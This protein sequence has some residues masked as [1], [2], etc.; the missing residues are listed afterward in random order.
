MKKFGVMIAAFC[1]ALLIVGCNSLPPASEGMGSAARNAPEG[2]LIGQAAGSSAQA[3]E[4]DAKYQLAR[5]MSFMVKDLVDDSVAANAI[6]YNAAEAFRQGVNTALGRNSLSAAVKEGSGEGAGKVFW[7]VYYMEKAE[8]IKVI[9]QA[10]TASKSLH[11]AAAD[12]TIEGRI[13]R[14]YAT[15]AA[16]EWKKN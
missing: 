13:D 6:E 12:F 9:N 7:A 14:A 1:A 16:R 2:T 3:A 5:A 10:V 8:V 11:P 4:S 15:Y